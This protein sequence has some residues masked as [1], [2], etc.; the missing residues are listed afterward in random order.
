MLVKSAVVN[1]INSAASIE[2]QHDTAS[3]LGE[4]IAQ[5]F[6]RV[7]GLENQ[8]YLGGFIRWL[9]RKPL[10]NFAQLAAQFD[11]KVGDQGLST[12]ANLYL[13][14]IVDHFGIEGQE[15][16]PLDGPTIVASN[17]PGSLDILLLLASIQRD[18]I[19]VIASGA[20]FLKS[21]PNIN[22]FLLFTT[23][24][25]NDRLQALRG[26]LRHLQQGGCLVT[27]PTGLLDPDP[28]FMSNASSSFDRWH[29]SLALL[30]KKVPT[31]KVVPAVVSGILEPKYYNHPITRVF[32]DP[33]RRQK[34]SEY[35][36][37]LQIF[38]RQPRFSLTP[39]VS[40]GAPCQIPDSNS[41][42]LEIDSIMV[43]LTDRAK[44]LLMFHSE[45]LYPQADR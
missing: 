19:R 8:P 10:N 37:V 24:A 41:E 31:T 43:N 11:T 45:R 25:S 34:F 12:T 18:D 44:E 4:N 20:P 29:S 16:I 7:L 28:A 40:F 22:R 1:S 30:M 5:E 2:M 13:S 38:R 21:L 15:N 3:L 23:S 39:S 27:F 33:I 42:S 36:M 6:L 9:V 32:R 17:H 14:Q 35:W 26:A